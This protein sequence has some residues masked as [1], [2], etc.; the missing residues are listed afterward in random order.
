M[1]QGPDLK[2]LAWAAPSFAGMCYQTVLQ[3]SCLFLLVWALTQGSHDI[4][5]GSHMHSNLVWSLV[6]KLP[7]ESICKPYNNFVFITI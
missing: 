4:L 5:W 7:L 2:P 3:I 6:F 1:C